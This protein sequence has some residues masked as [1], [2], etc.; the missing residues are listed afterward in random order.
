MVAPSSL[1]E[2]QKLLIEGEK[3]NSS[4]DDTCEIYT[5]VKRSANGKNG[6]YTKRY[7]I[8]LYHHL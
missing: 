1:T 5:C 7:M 8:K 6:K 4:Y 2:E 3:D